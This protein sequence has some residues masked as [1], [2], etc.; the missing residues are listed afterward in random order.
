MPHCILEL[1]NNIADKPDMTS[2]FKKIHEFLAAS[3]DVQLEQIKSRVRVSDEFYIGSGQ[4]SKSYIYLQLSL[5]T[6][7]SLELRQSFGSKLLEFVEQ[8]FSLSKLDP[9]CSIT[10]EVREMERSTH[11]RT[12]CIVS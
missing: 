10:V 3:G 7:R 11:F 8:A 9:N 2:L 12:S 4:S 1:S 5:M 6:G